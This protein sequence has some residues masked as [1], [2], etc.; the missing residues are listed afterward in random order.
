MND[1]SGAMLVG[2]L[3]TTPPREPREPLDLQPASVYEVVT[4]QMVEALGRDVTAVRERV[5]ALFYLMI[6]S[7]ALDVL[8]RLAGG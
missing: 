5:D 8:L 3:A 6:A 1:M 7:I 2:G 4:R